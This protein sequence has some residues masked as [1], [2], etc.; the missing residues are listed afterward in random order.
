MSSA[1]AP[2]RAASLAIIPRDG[3]LALAM[4]T[5]GGLLALW[6]PLPAGLTLTGS[7]VLLLT[8]V[9]W[10]QSRKAARRQERLAALSAERDRLGRELDEARSRY[11]QILHHASDAMFLVDPHDG[12]LLE[13]NRRAEE[14]LGYTRGDIQHLSLG[15]LF[16][17]RHRRRFLKLVRKI[18]T[19]GQGE[20]PELQFRCKDGKLFIGAVQARL[21]WLGEQRVVHGSFHDATPYA[22]LASELRRHNQQLTLLNEVAR[23]AAEGQH[24]SSVLATILEQVVDSFG[25]AGGGIFLLRHHA[26]EMSLAFHRGIPPEVVAALAELRPGEG[27]LGKVAVSRQARLSVDLTKDRR[28]GCAVAVRDGWKAFLAV[29][30]ESKESCHG[31]LFLFE[32]GLRVLNRNDLRLLQAVARQIG[33]LVKHAELFDELQWQHRLNQASLRE[34]ERSRS[35]LR[36][37]LSQLEQNHR[38]LQ[39]LDQMKS[40]FMAL[41]SH[42]L[43]TPLTTIQSGAELLES[44]AAH[45]LDASGR[46]ALEAILHGTRRLRELV[47]DLLEAARLEANAIYLADEEFPLQ[48]LVE[49]LSGEFRPRCEQRCLAF[50]LGPLPAG[51]RLRGDRHHLQRAVGR[52]LENAVKFTP[53]GGSIR[54][55]AAVLDGASVAALADRL[56]PLAENF[57]AAT[58]APT[59]LRLCVRDSGIGLA[60]GD[61]ARIFDKFAT[62]GDIAS[63]SSSRERFGGKGAGL[64][65]TL[66]RGVIAAHDGLLWAESAG[67][68]QGSSF[69]LLL[70]LGARGNGGDGD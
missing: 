42:E 11:E 1:A 55:D 26:T 60:A 7:G 51:I 34:L 69:C 45:G 23:L 25:V 4:A 10:R 48:A 22:H 38:L 30:L 67:E 57:F 31:T 58:L 15:V 12:S 47:D 44:T 6:T 50:R 35:A 3:W 61:E 68:G 18:L 40:S 41:A 5:G 37:N 9:T 52:I 49:D 29:P 19:H 14:L 21:G 2:D 54:L 20:E 56:Q 65:L 43:R 13:V 59:Y 17:G 64:G 36:D 33:P 28:F 24:L 16:P 62:L 39:G 66:S 63:H 70:P 46:L 32:R 8:V 53:E 27:L